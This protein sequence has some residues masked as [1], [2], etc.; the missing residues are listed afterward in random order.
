MN[1]KLITRSLRALFLQNDYKLSNVYIFG[2][3][4]DF[5]SLTKSGYTIEVEIKISRSDFFADFKKTD[6]HEVFKNSSAKTQIIKRRNNEGYN[7]GYVDGKH[8][9]LDGLACQ[10]DYCSPPEKLPNRFF[11]A[12]PEKLIKP[13]EVPNYAGLIYINDGGFAT[14]I[15]KAPLLHKHKPDLQKTLLSKYYHKYENLRFELLALTRPYNNEDKTKEYILDK[16]K[17]IL[18]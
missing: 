5:F 8:K 1:S 2:W 10:F 12:C 17:N 13:E 9:K 6:K 14:V 18:S 3:E 7:W 16:I 11:Y 4:S 15:K